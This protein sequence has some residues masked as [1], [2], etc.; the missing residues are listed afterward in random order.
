MIGEMALLEHRPRN[1]AVVAETDMVLVSFDTEG[2]NE[3]LDANPV[4]KDRVS[5]L[6]S[7]RLSDNISRRDES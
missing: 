3:I 2:F 7:S 6:L 1:A 5:S 4:A